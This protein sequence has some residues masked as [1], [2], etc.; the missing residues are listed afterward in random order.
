MTNDND[1]SRRAEGHDRKSRGSAGHLEVTGVLACS[2]VQSIGRGMYD[3]DSMDTRLKIGLHH[4]HMIS[5]SVSLNEALLFGAAGR[6]GPVGCAVEAEAAPRPTRVA[7]E[8]STA[9]C[10]FISPP[11]GRCGS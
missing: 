6:A 9:M 8:R 10:L 2:T 7:A 3:R 11:I 4:H 1:K 5:P